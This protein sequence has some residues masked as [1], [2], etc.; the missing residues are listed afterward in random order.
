MFGEER[1]FT[2]VATKR[3]L[4]AI[5]DEVAGEAPAPLEPL[6]AERIA[7]TWLALQQAEIVFAQGATRCDL[8]AGGVEPEAYR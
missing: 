8:E 3:T 7:I 6:L 5:R 1:N 2:K 4:A